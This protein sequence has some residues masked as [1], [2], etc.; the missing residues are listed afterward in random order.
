MIYKILAV[1][2]AVMNVAAFAVCGG[3]KSAAKKGAWRVPEK[4]LFLLALLG[5]SLGLWLGMK[6]FRHKTKH[7]YFVVGVP[8]IFFL[9]AAICVF[10][11]LKLSGKI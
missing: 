10:A 11:Y 1:Y 9:Q 3:D 5:G 2:A 7:W 6:V 8:L 4:T